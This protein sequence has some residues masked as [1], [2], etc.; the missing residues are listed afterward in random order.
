MGLRKIIVT[1]SKVRQT[2]N[3]IGTS[4]LINRVSE[5]SNKTDDV[6]RSFL[7]NRIH[8]PLRGRRVRSSST[9]PR[10][11]EEREREAIESER[12]RAGEFSQKSLS[13]LLGFSADLVPRYRDY[14]EATASLVLP[15]SCLPLSPPTL[16]CFTL[17]VSPILLPALR[18]L[19]LYNFHPNTCSNYRWFVTARREGKRERERERE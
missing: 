6:L 10:K 2:R 8:R 17:H 14:D 18:P 4:R 9:Q 13:H 19:P 11:K 15:V 3:R 7:K 5:Y 1:R 16:P 12:E